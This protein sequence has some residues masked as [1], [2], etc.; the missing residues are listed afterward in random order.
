METMRDW[1]ESQGLVRR[2]AQEAGAEGRRQQGEGRPQEA[3]NYLN[4]KSTEED[5]KS[6]KG[7]T[8][9][10]AVLF[11]TLAKTLALFAVCSSCYFFF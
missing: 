1:A 6:A 5:A 8:S 11:A 9:I 4:A 7:S 2:Q 10:P 3:E